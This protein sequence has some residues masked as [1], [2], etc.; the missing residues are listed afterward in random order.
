MPQAILTIGMLLVAI[1]GCTSQRMELS[2]YTPSPTSTPKPSTTS[3]DVPTKA[4]TATPIPAEESQAVNGS[5]GTP[6]PA[7]GR[8]RQATA[9]QPA[10]QPFTIDS[11]LC[12]DGQ[13]PDCTKLR[14]G[15]D[16]LTTSGPAKGY[17][18]SCIGKN[19]NAPGSIESKITWIDFAHK[20]W[21]FLKKLWLPRGTF[22]PAAG[23]YSET[24]TGEKR[25]IT[26]NNLPVDGKIGDWPMTNYVA[27]TEIDPN[28]G[29]PTVRNLSFSYFADPSEAIS[30]S[31]V[32]LG[33]IGV[34]KNGVV[35]F[36]ASDA[37]GEDAVAR[38][39]VD[40]FGGHPAMSEYHYHFIP[41]RLDSEYLEDG[42]SGIVGY[43]NDG[44]PIYGYKG[45]GG[46]EMSNGDLD[47]CHGHKHG[48]SG[49]HYHATLEFPYTIGCYMG[50]EVSSSPGRGAPPR[51]Q[52]PRNRP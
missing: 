13:G 6:I 18:Y 14:L 9:T 30:P 7:S 48:T 50:N 35:I 47:L 52:P 51:R 1:S 15:D 5:P 23:I 31:C 17:L 41:E 11:T 16:Y 36:N 40:E 28:P 21:N 20:T 37:R 4:S 45:I 39:I 10:S 22:S 34:T 43:I 42:H 46:I 33:A 32:S 27:L 44:F 8:D 25:Q 2:T 49:Y 29:I 19:P 3:K 24:T 38:E 12:N 26:V